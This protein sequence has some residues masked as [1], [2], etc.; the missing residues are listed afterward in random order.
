MRIVFKTSVPNVIMIG[1]TIAII[2]SNIIY[3]GYDTYS[4]S[5]KM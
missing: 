5:Q 2:L 3:N 1:K 4:L